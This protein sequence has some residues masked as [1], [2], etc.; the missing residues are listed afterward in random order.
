[1]AGILLLWV[2]QDEKKRE[3]NTVV[4]AFFLRLPRRTEDFVWNDIKTCGARSLDLSQI[5]TE[6]ADDIRTFK[7]GRQS[8][9]GAGVFTAG[10]SGHMTH[11]FL[12]PPP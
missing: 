12:S 7:I 9:K 1:M 4:H 2:N 10:A 11:K 5:T 3:I 8:L 6:I